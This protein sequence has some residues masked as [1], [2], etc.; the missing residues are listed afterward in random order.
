MLVHKT[1]TPEMPC[2]E[3]PALLNFQFLQNQQNSP[4]NCDV[5]TYITAVIT[6][7]TAVITYITAVITDTTAVTTLPPT[8]LECNP[9][10]HNILMLKL[11]QA[12]VNCSTGDETS[13]FKPFE[14]QC[15][16]N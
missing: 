15:M 7:I 9:V 6:Y 3:V 10:L 5:I 13:A 11:W 14:A 4:C 8:C 2:G 12:H 16:K 1:A